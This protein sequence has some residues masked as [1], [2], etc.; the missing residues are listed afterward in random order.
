[1]AAI[2]KIARGN[3]DKFKENNSL[4]EGVLFWQRSNSNPDNGIID[5]GTLYIGDPN[6]EDNNSADPIEIGGTRAG[7]ALNYRGVI[8]HEVAD[9]SNELFKYARVG[10]FWQ[11]EPNDIVGSTQVSGHFKDVDRFRKSDLLIITKVTLK[12]NPDNNK[13]ETGEVELT[14]DNAPK[15]IR[16]AGNELSEEAEINLSGTNFKAL[17]IGAALK[18]LE[19]EKLSFRGNISSQNQI[20]EMMLSEKNY[21]HIGSLYLITEDYL[22]FNNHGVDGIT[23]TPFTTKRGDFVIWTSN[24]SDS[25]NSPFS[26]YNPN[27]KSEESLIKTNCWVKISS[28]NSDSSDI[29]YLKTNDEKD[30]LKTSMEDMGTFLES[31]I[32]EATQSESVKEALDILFAKKAQ[33]DIYGK[34]PLSQLHDTVLGS[35]QYKGIWNPLNNNITS[36]NID[37]YNDDGT[38]LLRNLPENQSPWPTGH[39]DD[40]YGE[41]GLEG[42]NKAANGDYYVI[43]ISQSTSVSLNI[44]YRDKNFNDINRVLELNNGDWIVFQASNDETDPLNDGHNGKWEKIDNTA[45]LSGITTTFNGKVSFASD[46]KT[47]ITVLDKEKVIDLAGSPNIK[48]THKIKIYE[49][50]SNK[51]SINIGGSNLVDQRW[52]NGDIYRSKNKY[53]PRYFGTS[54]T[55]ENGN[56]IDYSENEYKNVSEALD[57]KFTVFESNI[58]VGE[59]TNR[60]QA[61]IFGDFHIKPTI[62]TLGGADSYKNGSFVFSFRDTK[63]IE[64]KSIIKPNI[65]PELGEEKLSIELTLPSRTSTLLSQLDYND[66]I[67]GTDKRLPLF[68]PKV[69]LPGDNIDVNFSKISDSKVRQYK[70][71]L[72]ENLL[73]RN[74]I[75]DREITDESVFLEESI[76]N[77][78]YGTKDDDPENETLI[79]ETDLIVGKILNEGNIS[80]SRSL[81]VTKS[82]V[83]G[84]TLKKKD[85]DNPDLIT[86]ES[87]K[88]TH[89][90]PGRP[91]DF[92][93]DT[94]YFDPYTQS[95]DNPVGDG[96]VETDVIVAVPAKSGVLLTSNSRIDG[97]LWV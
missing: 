75:T 10:D 6:C 54:N 87:T 40:F 86:L 29:D 93:D 92:L 46:N 74:S 66:L 43:Q 11:F 91:D 88:D 51:N 96:V 30:S 21:P 17:T 77:S 34:I 76:I 13:V 22:T 15:Y 7:K 5:E 47:E 14:G 83:L 80:E 57:E 3:L 4:E 63:N 16:V 27:K 78:I 38:S 28:G 20:N 84:G 50:S 79:V 44:L 64:R 90:F 53:I 31:H 32:V 26:P 49:D 95:I 25:D 67:S 41:N 52:G 35:L 60:K 70:D 2:I 94:Q 82:F 12:K 9:I 23:L 59:Q 8:S 37:S 55:L 18:E 61:F 45:R 42:N 71:A 97:K 48:A 65:G 39:G 89:F 85:K 19:A 58:S 62:V 24:I 73:K 36:E 56:I 1:M 33:L 72:I 68:G 69:D 81:K